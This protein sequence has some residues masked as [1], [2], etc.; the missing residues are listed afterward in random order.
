MICKAAFNRIKPYNILVVGNTGVGKSTLIGTILQI[1]ISDTVTT[2]ISEKP[3]TTP[4]SSFT[5][6]DTPGLERDEKQRHRVK[7]DIANLIRQQK[8]WRKEPGE[9][10][11]AVWYCINSQNTRMC[12]IDEKWIADLAKEVPVIAV[13]TRSLSKQTSQFHKKLETNPNIRHVVPVLAEEEKTEVGF[14]DPHGLDSLR[15]ITEKFLEEIA[16]AAILNAVNSK[17]NEAFGWCRDGCAKV[18]VTQFLPIPGVKA[19][20]ASLFQTRLFLDITK[21]FGYRFAKS[22]ITEL[23]TVGLGTVGFDLVKEILKHLPIDYNNIQTGK[24]FLSYLT[25]PLEQV[26]GE[27]PFKEQLLEILSGVANCNLISGLPILSYIPK[28]ATILSTGM[29]AIA[30]IEAL[31]I[32]KTSEY[33]GQPLSLEELKKTLAEQLKLVVEVMCLPWMGGGGWSTDSVT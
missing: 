23:L 25:T 6:Y 32:Y 10:I 33:K 8:Q 19:P 5:V 22:F 16:Q 7:Q 11:H 12:D 24:D 21:T 2:K 3:Y 31:K 9:H 28:I 13:I 1:P 15:D 26:A 27:L 29:I 4:R 14:I 18:L 17:A 30:Y 20:A